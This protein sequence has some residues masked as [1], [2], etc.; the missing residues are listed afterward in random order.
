MFKA[1]L[2][3]EK[4]N[5]ITEID[6]EINQIY[7]ILKGSGTFIGLWEHLDV[8]IMKCRES[9]FELVLNENILPAPF[10]TE[11]VLG[12]VLLIRMDINSEPQDF[13]LKEYLSS[14]QK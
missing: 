14:F 10:D 5:D 1:V 3:A 12:C 2:I 9:I 7:N 4:K 11:V 8:V 6:L 13:T